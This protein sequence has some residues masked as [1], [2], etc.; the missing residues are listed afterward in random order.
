MAV[1]KV[2]LADDSYDIH[3]GEEVWPEIPLFLQEKVQPSRLLVITDRHVAALY[4]QRLQAEL[5]PLGIPL[6]TA[7]V[8]PGETAKSMDSCMEVYTKAIEGGL[9]RK[10]AIIALGGGVVG[11]LAGF[12]A[13][14]YL[15]G[16]S[17]IQVP[18][19]LLALVDSSVGGKVAVNHPLGK[20]L[21]GA[22]Y[23][24]KAVFAD[25]RVLHTLPRRELVTGLAEVIK[26]GVIADPELFA[27]LEQHAAQYLAGDLS[28]LADAVRRSCAIKADIVAKD[29][30]ETSLRMLLNFGH[31]IGHAVETYSQ[32]GCYTHGEA[33]G[34]GMYGAARIAEKLGLCGQPLSLR[35]RQACENFGLPWQATNCRAAGLLPILFRDKKAV[36][37]AIQWVL[38]RGL[39]DCVITTAVP[40][41]IV[42]EVL[43]EITGEY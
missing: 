28:V 1:V 29:E 15:R 41:A 16:I 17:F 40:Q 27:A 3:I 14:T 25:L 11:D 7:I 12:V 34:I 10:S 22:F 13:A 42:E 23:Q 39:G 8:A 33:V 20:N 37:G 19:S 4:G 35:L 24:P 31:T 26:Y 32:Y 38:P 18:T 6:A 43:R 5:E 2:A 21:I 36:G 9:D 30:K